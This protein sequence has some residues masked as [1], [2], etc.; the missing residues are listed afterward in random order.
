MHSNGLTFNQFT[1]T[2]NTKQFGCYWPR[3]AKTMPDKSN[4]FQ[5]IQYSKESGFVFFS[6]FTILISLLSQMEISFSLIPCSDR[7]FYCVNL[8]KCHYCAFYLQNTILCLF[9][10][11]VSSSKRVICFILNNLPLSMVE[12]IAFS[13]LY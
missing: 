8:N 12:G 2:W 10:K 9:L 13:A 11:N 5:C 4:V 7:H 6:I 1:S 3:Q